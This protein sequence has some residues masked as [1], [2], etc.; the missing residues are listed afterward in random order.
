MSTR[1]VATLAHTAVLSLLF[2]LASTSAALADD[3]TPPPE[4]HPNLLALAWGHP[5]PSTLYLGMWTKHFHPGITN[6]A[7]VAVN[8]RG[9]FAGT[10]LN[11]WHERSYAAGI[12]RSI[13]RRQLGGSGAYNLGYR[14]GAINGYDSRLI[15]G[16]G[17]TPVVPFLQILANGSYKRVGV[18]A[19]YCW[20]VFTGGFF[21][22]L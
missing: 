4:E 16:A 1:R 11:S 15:K 7:M 22:R 19:S 21:V 6:N 17:A 8:F 2:L 20:L 3:E 5:E 12:E 13:L 9:Y 10:F 18:Q 14:V